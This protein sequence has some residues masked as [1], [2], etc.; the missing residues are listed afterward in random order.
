[1]AFLLPPSVDTDELAFVWQ[2]LLRATLGSAQFTQVAWPWWLGPALY[3]AGG[4]VVQAEV[5]DQLQQLAGLGVHFLGGG[6]QL[7]GGG[8]ILL[9]DLVH[10][11]HGDVDLRRAERRPQQAL[12]DEGQFVS[13]N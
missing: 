7:L 12:P 13:F 9:G 2:C 11:A 4:L 10:L 8:S 1:M 3:E 5:A 6:G